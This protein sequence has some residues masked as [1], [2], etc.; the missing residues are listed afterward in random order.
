VDHRSD[1]YGVDAAILM[2]QRVWQASGHVE[3]FT[4]PLI[5]CNR[6]KEKFKADELGEKTL[7][8]KC[9]GCGKAGTLT[10]SSPFQMMFETYVG[11]KRDSASISYLRPETAQGIFTNYKNVIDSF[12]P[13]IPFGIAQIGKAFRNEIA[14]RDFLFRAR[15]FEQMEMQY[16]I[17]KDNQQEEFEKW[18]KEA[19]ATMV[20]M[21]LPESKM[22]WHEH[23][24]EERAHY[25]AAAVDIEYEF[26]FGMLELHG[27]HNRTDFDLTAHMKESGVDL[28]YFDQETNERYIPYVIETSV[29]LDRIIL[30]L[31][32]SAYTEEEVKGEK[33]VVLKFKPEIAPVKVAVLPLM[34]KEELVKKAKEVYQ[35]VYKVVP[36]LY[37]ETGSIGKRYRRQDEIGTPIA[38]T[39]DYDTLEDDTVTIRDR[40]TMEQERVKISELTQRLT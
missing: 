16:F 1:I 38:I 11:A 18:K 29:G 19:W 40:D 32:D 13:R 2:N 28:K 36:A 4:D 10:E 33:R 8:K 14:P 22:G 6:C 7:L 30:A 20:A 23:T 12:H 3:G 24:D 39:I 34:R 27:I 21:G 37:D 5:E 26:P 35:V 15:E 17:H 31:L 9:P 25:A